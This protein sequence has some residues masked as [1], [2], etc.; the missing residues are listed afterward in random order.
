MLNPIQHREA[1]LEWV[2]AKP[3][4]LDLAMCFQVPSGIRWEE[5][6]HDDVWLS[7]RLKHVFTDLDR[8][9]LGSANRRRHLHLDRIVVLHNSPD[10]GWHA[11]CQISTPQ[12]LEQRELA[13]LAGRLWLRSLGRYASGAFQQRLFWSEPVVAGHLPYM[14]GHLSKDTID[15]ENTLLT[16]AVT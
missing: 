13:E 3:T 5:K 11:H 4:K 1:L 14:F 6:G 10:V 8:R 16:C 12:K 9:A 15:W 2:R 7:G